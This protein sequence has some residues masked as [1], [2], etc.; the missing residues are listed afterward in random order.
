MFP[1]PPKQKI[2]G[3]TLSS[4]PSTEKH[5][6][7]VCRSAYVE[8]QRINNICHYLA[9]DATKTLV[10][11]FVLSKLDHCNSLL[12]GCS[13]QLPNKQQRS[14]IL[15]Q[16]SSSKLASKNT[17]NPFFKNSTGYQSTQESSTKSQ[18]CATI[19]SLKLTRSVCLN[20]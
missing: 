17:P 18:P 3:V 9:T 20:F 19:L 5:V 12:S 16:D 1:F 10:C 11:A 15:Q 6:T 13:N 14:K 2:L 4:N 8:I 7:N